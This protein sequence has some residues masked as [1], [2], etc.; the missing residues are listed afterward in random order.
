MIKKKTKIDPPSEE[1]LNN[2]LSVFKSFDKDGSGFIDIK[3]IQLAAKELGQ[4]LSD[5]E[6]KK[7]FQEM[8]VNKD[9]KIS[10]KEFSDW[11]YY[12]KVNKME[13]L[14]FLKLKMMNLL[15]KNKALQSRLGKVLADKY[16]GDLDKISFGIQVGDTEPKSRIQLK[17]STGKSSNTIFQA[18]TTDMELSPNFTVFIKAKPVQEPKEAEVNLREFISKLKQLEEDQEPELSNFIMDMLQFHVKSDD[19][20]VYLGMST[21]APIMKDMLAAPVTEALDQIHDNFDAEL[22]FSMAFKHDLGTLLN[23]LQNEKLVLSL[24]E[25]FSFN[26]NGNISSEFAK[27]LRHEFISH[28]ESAGDDIPQDMKSLLILSLLK[29]FKANIKFRE[30]EKKKF[31]RILTAIGSAQAL[32]ATP[33]FIQIVEL[34]KKIGLADTY[35]EYPFLKKVFTFLRSEFKADIEIYIK[36]KQL[37]VSVS[38]ETSGLGEFYDY[39]IDRNE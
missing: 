38:L 15:S 31:E 20:Y 12:G 33:S 14:V 25:G 39:I 22:C 5:D 19:Q 11:W 32:K 4:E 27:N 8:D 24:L 7:I 35:K 13:S 28:L 26:V 18:L 9:K 23:Q 10:F 36:I 16:E 3:E 30:L 21:E 1:T 29:G 2:M 6:M 37:L 17:L 34:L